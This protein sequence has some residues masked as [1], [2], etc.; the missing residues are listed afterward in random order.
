MKKPEPNTS[1]SKDLKG[2]KPKSKI[3]LRHQTFKPKVLNDP[4][5]TI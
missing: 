3:H 4:S 2:S 5:L 1:K